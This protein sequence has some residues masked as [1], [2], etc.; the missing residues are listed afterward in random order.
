MRKRRS[1]RIDK[2]FLDFEVRVLRQVNSVRKGDPYI[3]SLLSEKLCKLKRHKEAFEIDQRLVSR[4]PNDPVFRYNLACSYAQL[5][6]FESALSELDLALK[7]GFSD[8]D[9]VFKDS[10]LKKLILR[11]RDRVLSLIK[12]YNWSKTG[13]T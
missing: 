10:D 12:K 2:D 3:M 11:H 9:Y 7:Y 5:E 6:D 4:F 1:A 8:I 13:G